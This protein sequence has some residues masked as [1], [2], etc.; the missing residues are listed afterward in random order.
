MIPEAWKDSAGH[1]HGERTR[2]GI[3]IKHRGR[4]IEIAGIPGH[5]RVRSTFPNGKTAEITIPTPQ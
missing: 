3:A 1:T 5:F 2:S 4:V